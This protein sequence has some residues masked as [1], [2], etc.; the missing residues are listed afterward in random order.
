MNLAS[1]H[2][3]PLFYALKP[4]RRKP[5]DEAIHLGLY[6]FSTHCAFQVTENK[7]VIISVFLKISVAGCSY[8][9]TYTSTDSGDSEIEGEQVTYLTEWNSSVIEFVADHNIVIGSQLIL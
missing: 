9:S 5:W 3:F 1:L 2:S 8:C 6:Q 7:A 4:R